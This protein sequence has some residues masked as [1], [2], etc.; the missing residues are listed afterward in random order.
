[1]SGNG[2]HVLRRKFRTVARRKKI[3]S[4]MVYL[5]EGERWYKEEC[6]PEF[7]APYYRE[8]ELEYRVYKGK[9][10]TFAL[11]EDA[12]DGYGYEQG[13]YKITMLEWNEQEKRLSMKRV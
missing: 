7:V 4:G 8:D 10:A 2:T 11:Y 12:G 5:P 6:I 3:A 1:M 13:E 9:D